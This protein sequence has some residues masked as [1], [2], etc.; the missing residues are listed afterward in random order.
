MK[1]NFIRNIVVGMIVIFL[2]ICIQKEE[3]LLIPITIGGIFLG[4]EFLKNKKKKNPTK[5]KWLEKYRKM[6]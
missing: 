2:L 4:V 5:E 3:L 6:Y 1:N